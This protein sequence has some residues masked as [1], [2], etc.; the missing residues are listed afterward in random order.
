MLNFER[1]LWERGVLR[2]AGVDEAGRGPLAGPVAA[3]AVIFP[4]DVFIPGVKDSKL[5][6]PDKREA[7]FRIIREEAL[8]VSVG[9]VSEKVIDRI[10]ILQATYEAMRT[11]LGRLKCRPE[12]VL[13]DGRSIPDIPY[14]QTPIV[15]GDRK[16]FSIAAASIVAK[17]IRDRIMVAFDRRYPGYGFLR[18][19]GY[20][21]REHVKAIRDLGYCPIHRRSFRIKGLTIPP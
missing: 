3:A 7:L 5:L 9:I 11:A 16:S 17:V 19:K 6:K 8:E 4:P 18:H 12:H 14:T 15:G 10:N 1:E 20:G 2:V 13:V 21:T